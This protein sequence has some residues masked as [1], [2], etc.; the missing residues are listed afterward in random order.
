[1]PTVYSVVNRL[2]PQADSSKPLPWV[3]Q[4]HQLSCSS[5]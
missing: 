2:V 3:L 1:M 5:M 4:P